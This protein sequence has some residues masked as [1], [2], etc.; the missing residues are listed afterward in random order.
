MPRISTQEFERLPL[1]VHDFLAGVPLH[2]VWAVDLPRTR[3]GITLDEFS[4]TAN[5]L[6]FTMRDPPRARWTPPTPS[7]LLVGSPTLLVARSSQ[8]ARRDIASLLL[9]A[10][11][12]EV[13]VARER[14]Q[15]QVGELHQGPW[16]SPLSREFVTCFVR[17]ER[18][19][20]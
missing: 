9:T 3:S 17:T 4:R 14:V 1:R 13:V 12:C 8:K 10:P 2:D 5:A 6:R 19:D 18:N 16:R 11:A 15:I 7:A 20:V